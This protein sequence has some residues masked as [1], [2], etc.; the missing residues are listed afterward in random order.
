M[1]TISSTFLFTA[2]IFFFSCS[3]QEV[4][5]AH[6]EKQK[7]LL[8]LIYDVSQ[9]NG[10]HEVLSQQHL[11]QI[12]NKIA[13]NGGGSFYACHILGN[14]W[15]QEILEYRIDHCD[16][17]MGH[18]HMFKFKYKK[19]K[20]SALKDLKINQQKFVEE[21]SRKLIIPKIADFSDIEQAVKHA[22]RIIKLPAYR[23]YT[24]N[25]IIVSDGI[26]DLPPQ[27]GQDSISTFELESAN[28]VIMVK[29]RNKKYISA[30]E[31]VL[32]NTIDEAIDQIILE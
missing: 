19:R 17:I 15:Q 6:S 2:I 20:K 10:K 18:A 24:K 1:K 21:V 25:I 4:N 28:S 26:Q 32:S 23:D 14:S 11:K 3:D 9:S 29:A 22:E 5:P 8:F 31:P 13:F 7:S 12:Y 27:L 16:T 30:P